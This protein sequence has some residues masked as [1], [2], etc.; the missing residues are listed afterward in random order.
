GSV[1]AT[2]DTSIVNVAMPQIRG[3]LGAS[4]QEITWVTTAYLIAMVLVMPLTGFLGSFFGQKRV[5]I[6]SLV[7]FTIGSVLCGTARSLEMLGVW[8]IVQG[9]GGGAVPATEPAMRRQTVPPSGE[10]MAD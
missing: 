3:E 9:I 2:I 1:M 5:Y 10:G 7:L 8:R 4:L 6:A